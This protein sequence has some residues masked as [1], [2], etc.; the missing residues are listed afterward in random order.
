MYMDV[1]KEGT[2][3]LSPF[4]GREREEAAAAPHELL[5]GAKRIIRFSQ[6][7]MS[8]QKPSIASQKGLAAPT[9]L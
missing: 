3:H 7:T 5:T 9:I 1:H 6:S 4:G 8:L 2:E